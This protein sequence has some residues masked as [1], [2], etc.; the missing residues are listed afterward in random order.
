MKYSTKF[1]IKGISSPPSPIGSALL[2]PP[3][4]VLVVH[5]Q[6]S[7]S[8]VVFFHSQSEPLATRTLHLLEDAEVLWTETSK[9]ARAQCLPQTVIARPD[10]MVHAWELHP[11][12]QQ[13]VSHD[14]GV[15]SNNQLSRRPRLPVSSINTRP[16]L[17]AMKPSPRYTQ[18][19]SDNRRSGK[20]FKTRAI[21]V[22]QTGKHWPLVSW[23]R[24]RLR[25]P[26][27]L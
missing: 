12:G 23:R 7:H 22:D 18:A 11:L 10:E 14:P 8:F 15:G 3:N 13:C 24:R 6:H 19:A 5:S 17:K 25:I 2:C 27:Y 16:S 1:S 9:L 4:P 26:G 20:H 21:P